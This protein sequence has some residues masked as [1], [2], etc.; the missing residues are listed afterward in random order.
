MDLEKMS[1]DRLFLIG[2]EA[3]VLNLMAQKQCDGSKY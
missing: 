3:V 1:I 2:V